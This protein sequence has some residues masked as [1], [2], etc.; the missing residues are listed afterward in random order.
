MVMIIKDDETFFIMK[1]DKRGIYNK[2]DKIRFYHK[3]PIK[4]MI[5][6]FHSLTKM[7]LVAFLFLVLFT[8]QNKILLAK[9]DFDQLIG[10]IL[11]SLI[12]LLSL[13][14]KIKERLYSGSSS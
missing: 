8:N 9:I 6:F 14:Y 1:R 11:V 5:R 4:A 7:I 12:I 2:S 3:F 10:I 13:T